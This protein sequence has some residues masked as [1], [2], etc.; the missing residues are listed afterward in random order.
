MNI[1][2]RTAAEPDYEDVNRVFTGELT[3][4]VTLLPDRFQLAD[5][6]M[7]RDWFRE[8]LTNANKTLYV[9]EVTDVIAGLIL[10]VE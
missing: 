10:L 9:A 7:P 8:L 5:P 6:V 4:H 1:E 2:I 3:H